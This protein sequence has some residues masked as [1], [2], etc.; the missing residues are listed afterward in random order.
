MCA[1][2]GAGF[3]VHVSSCDLLLGKEALVLKESAGAAPLRLRFLGAN[4]NSA[5]SRL[6]T[7]RVRYANVY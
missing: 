2:G 7:S 3:T 1:A 6:G 4:R 5:G